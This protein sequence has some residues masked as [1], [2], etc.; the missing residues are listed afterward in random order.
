MSLYAWSDIQQTPQ[1]ASQ[2][3]HVGLGSGFLK[4][5]GITSFQGPF[6]FPPTQA[7]RP[8]AANR[9]HGLPGVMDDVWLQAGSRIITSDLDECKNEVQ[10]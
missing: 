10:Q 4:W 2:P 1:E 7:V 6:G 9:R 3:F 5:G 8:E